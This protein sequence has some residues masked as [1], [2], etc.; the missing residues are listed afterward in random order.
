MSGC[1]HD[2]RNCYR[3]NKQPVSQCLQQRGSFPGRQTERSRQQA[4]SLVFFSSQVVSKHRRAEEVRKEAAANILFKK[5]IIRCKMKLFS[6]CEDQRRRLL[7]IAQISAG[8]GYS[9]HG[10]L[11]K[12]R[13]RQMRPISTSQRRATATRNR[14]LSCISSPLEA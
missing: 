3:A 4:G 2:C 1:K 13:P 7:S 14:G 12:R 8:S 11:S 10:A 9:K 5:C 6:R